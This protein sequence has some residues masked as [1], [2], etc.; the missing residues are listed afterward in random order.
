MR[1]ALA[2]LIAAAAVLASVP[3]AAQERSIWALV[4]NEEPKG[5]ID[6]LL[7]PDGPWVD[8]AALLAAGLR[9]L[10][11]GRRNVFPP[12]TITRVAMSSLAPLITFQLDEAE[13]RLLVSADPSLLSS[14]RGRHLPPA[15]TRMEGHLE[16]GHLPELLLELV[17]RRHHHRL[18]RA[19]HPPL[20]HAVPER[21][22]RRRNRC[23]H[24]RLDQ[25]H[26]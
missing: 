14:D 17:D 3:A 7:M 18:R 20:R 11:E 23:D 1:S 25:L 8:P 21:R 12:D 13:I 10:P 16:Q 4:V 22:Q 9:S 6:L 19:R 2:V 24:A 5:D 26:G 15:P